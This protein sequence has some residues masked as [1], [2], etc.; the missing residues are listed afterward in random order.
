MISLDYATYDEIK[1]YYGEVPVSMRAVV[2]KDDERVIGIGGIGYFDN[3]ML[4]FGKFDDELRRSP[5]TI[6][7]AGKMD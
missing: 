3:Q 6:L 7:K 5:K 2:A 1:E 4:V